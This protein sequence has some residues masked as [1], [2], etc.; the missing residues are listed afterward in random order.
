MSKRRLR[1]LVIRN[2]WQQDAGGAEQYALNLCV[3][4]E[5]AGHLP[6]L[7]TKV[8]DI[9]EKSKIG[10][11]PY[12]MGSWRDNQ[13][14]SRSYWFRYP[15]T[16]L[17]YLWI[18]VRHRIDIVHPQSRDDFIFATKAA[19]LLRKRVVWT[20]HADLKYIL[21]PNYAPRLRSWV[22]QTAQKADAIICVS[23]SEKRTILAVAPQLANLQVIHNGV[24]VPHVLQVATKTNQYIVGTN[25]RLV[26]SKGIAELLE[27][28]ALLDNSRWDLWLL[29][30]FSGNKKTYQQLARKLGITKQVKFLGYHNNPND[31]V[32]AMDIFVH[33]SY[34]EAFSLAVIEAAMLGKPIIATQVG[35]TPEIIDNQCGILIPP[36][37][38]EALHA[39][40]KQLIKD[41]QHRQ[42]L[43]ALAKNKAIRQF[44]FQRLVEEK[45]LLIYK[46][47]KKS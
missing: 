8:R 36:K 10:R 46:R 1:V 19:K 21:A 37:D 31:F 39:A 28:F 47:G 11:I 33:A 9:V 18:I 7:I 3:A 40:L 4:L 17:W 43:G 20:D 2:A 29:G 12:R 23:E 5:H 22:L 34:H 13:E 35:G 6:L 45:L 27:A 38:R 42:E 41:P 24:F 26:P 15:L 25:A 32:A 16:V 44:D 30:G 14:W